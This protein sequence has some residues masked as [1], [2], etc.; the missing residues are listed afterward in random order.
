[1]TWRAISSRPYVKKWLD[2]TDRAL[3]ARVS[4]KCGAAVAAAGLA[5]PRTH[6]GRRA[7]HPRQFV[8]SVALLRWAREQGRGYSDEEGGWDKSLVPPGTRGSV[9]LSITAGGAIA[10]C[11]LIHAEVSLLFNEIRHST[12]VESPPPSFSAHLSELVP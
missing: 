8:S 7:F 11:L 1:M 2:P 12:V 10:W 9:S 5:T 4:R 3:F 6:H